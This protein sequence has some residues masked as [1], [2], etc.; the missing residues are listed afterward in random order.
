MAFF[1]QR[2]SLSVFWSNSKWEEIASATSSLSLS[3]W[4]WSLP[5]HT[6]KKRFK[7][8]RKSILVLESYQDASGDDKYSLIMSLEYAWWCSPESGLT[9]KSIVRRMIKIKTITPKQICVARLKKQKGKPNRKIFLQD[10]LCR[11]CF[12]D[13]DDHFWFSADFSNTRKRMHI[14]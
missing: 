12:F 6:D 11:F 5:S 10:L 14:V 13:I 1:W 8:S 9:L 7:Y 2:F 4:N 3:N